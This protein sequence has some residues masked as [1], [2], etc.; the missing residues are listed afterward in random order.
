MLLMLQF[1]VSVNDHIAPDECGT[2]QNHQEKQ[3]KHS[4]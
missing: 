2:M 1:E 3:D 4:W